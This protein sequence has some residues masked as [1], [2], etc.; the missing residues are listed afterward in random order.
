[1]LYNSLTEYFAGTTSPLDIPE[2]AL[3]IFSIMKAEVPTSHAKQVDLIEAI[4][5]VIEESEEPVKAEIPQKRPTKAQLQ[6]DETMKKAVKK[7]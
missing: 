3:A 1:M 7:K 5:E 2:K 6:R 4:A